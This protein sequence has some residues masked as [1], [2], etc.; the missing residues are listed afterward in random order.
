MARK[1]KPSQP[2]PQTVT[3]ERARKVYE[4]LSEADHLEMLLESKTFIALCQFL[5]RCDTKSDPSVGALHAA[6]DRRSEW[7]RKDPYYLADVFLTFW[8][9]HRPPTWVMD[10]VADGLRKRVKGKGRLDSLLGFGGGERA[11]KGSK[12]RSHFL[13]QFNDIAH[14]Q[15]LGGL[16]TKPAAH[17]VSLRDNPALRAARDRAS[18]DRLESM[19][20]YLADA[21]G[22]YPGRTQLRE[23]YKLALQRKPGSEK[24]AEFLDS[25]P[26]HQVLAI[27]ALRKLLSS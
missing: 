20:N 16:K 1:K 27:P 9:R 8:P 23:F 5:E 24:T 26:R 13:K 11:L 12:R 4:G 15:A 2:R 25:F 14:L 19:T 22:R 3:P 7:L 21:F 6:L 10:W 17:L 18:G